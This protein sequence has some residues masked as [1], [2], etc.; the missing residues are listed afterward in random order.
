MRSPCALIGLEPVN[1][2]MRPLSLLVADLEGEPYPFEKL[3]GRFVLVNFWLTSCGPCL[4]ELPALI[5][6]ASR[7]AARG[8]VLVLVATDKVVKDV[9]GFLD[10]VPRLKTLP[11]N[12]FILSDS[13]GKIARSLGTEKYP[14]T[15]LINPDGSWG[16]RVVGARNW[17]ARGSVDCVLE[18]L[19]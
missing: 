13:G 3:R 1:G 4:E 11:P 9:Q 15:Y 5:D 7:F 18:H 8:L 14:E 12:A 16:G 2:T 10:K 19:P 17:T 6:L